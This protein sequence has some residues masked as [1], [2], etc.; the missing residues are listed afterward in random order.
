MM[1]LEYCIN[2]IFGHA[3]AHRRRARR[4]VLSRYACFAVYVRAGFPSKQKNNYR[5]EYNGN[6]APKPPFLIKSLL[7]P[8]LRLGPLVH[9][10]NFYLSY[11][12][13]YY[14][15]SPNKCPGDWN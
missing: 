14:F 6:D 1:G 5:S 2:D 11:S 15:M 7:W 12:N 8:E 9:K 10:F 4:T 13:L 3:V